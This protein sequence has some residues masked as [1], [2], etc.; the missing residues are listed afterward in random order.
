MQHD[1]LNKELE[2]MI[3]DE[4]IKVPGL[5]LIVCAGGREVFSTFLGSRTIDNDDRSKDK[6]LTRD[7]RL[8]AASV[9]KPFVMF[10][11]MQL[12]ERRLIDLDENVEHLLKFPLRNPNDPSTEITVRML[13]SH[14]S[15]LRDGKIYSVPPDV[16]I[17]ECFERGGRYWEEGAHFAPA[18]EPIG[19]H[20]A[21]CNLNY[22][23]L[24][25]IV[26]RVTGI[27]FD[28]YQKENI[29]A[30]LDIEADYV[31]A[32]LER[33]QFE[34]LGSIYRKSDP[35]G[36]W[37]ATRDA[38]DVQPPNDMLELQN[39]YS[40]R[41]NGAYDLKNYRVG[42][43]ATIFSPQGGLRISFEELSHALEMMI[44]GGRYRGRRVLSDR[45]LDQMIESNWIYDPTVGNGDNYGGAMN[46]YGLG[47]Y[48]IG[49]G[50]ARVSMER[51]IDLIGHTGAAFGM[52]SGMFFERS[53]GDGLIYMINGLA[54]DE[55]N[56]PRAQGRFS[57]NYIWEE[58]LFHIFFRIKS[59]K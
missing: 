7:T 2:S 14:T 53:T 25:T 35:R 34:L 11:V 57:A 16:S 56:D 18:D 27:R 21:Y 41:D 22:G 42:T 30:Q 13:A 9:S 4:G 43:N 15:S 50:T 54:L 51:E 12:V 3:G 37:T 26:E 23:L 19:K 24:G 39:A 10:T 8:R 17:E 31:P 44:C 52:L 55:D 33:D 1:R 28:R 32:N 45:S 5:G 29:L 20:F 38:Y 48:R 40:D 59:R 47:L 49:R 6:P 36:V 58:K 46:N